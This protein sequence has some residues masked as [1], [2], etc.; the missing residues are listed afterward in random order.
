MKFFTRFLVVC[1]LGFATISLTGCGDTV[2]VPPAHVAKKST[3]SGLEKGIIPPCKM[4]LSKMCLTCD[5]LVLAEASDYGVKETT[6][7]FMPKDKLNLVLDTRGIFSISAEEKNVE[8]IFSRITA[9][10]TNNARVSL[11]SMQKVYDTYG[12][13]VV[14]EAVRTVI[15]KYSIMEVMGN[16]NAISQELAKLVRERLKNTPITVIRFGLADAQPPKMI[17]EAQEAATKREIEIRQTE[18][19][20]MVKLKEAEA[21]LEVA[22]KQQEVD[23]VEAETQV[24]VAKKLAE[25][26]SPAWITQRSIKALE[27]LENGNHVILLPTEVYQNPAMMVGIMTKAFSEK[28]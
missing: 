7:I 22:R 5:S 25:G 13:P 28:N 2:E 11:I 8:K 15:T 27:K 19:D 9:Q 26:V 18:A 12:A 24:L 20:K 21:D 1:L 6:E 16:R 4:R 3:P 14:R 23:L 10:P 17:I